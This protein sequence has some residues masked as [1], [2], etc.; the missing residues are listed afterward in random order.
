MGKQVSKHKK[1]SVEEDAETVRE[2]YVKKMRD[3]YP[4]IVRTLIHNIIVSVDKDGN[5]VFV[6][7]AAVEFLEVK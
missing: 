7:D 6:N 4:L 3:N 5:F 2:D 1:R